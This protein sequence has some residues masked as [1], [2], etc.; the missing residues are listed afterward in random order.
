VNHQKQILHDKIRGAFERELC[1]EIFRS[2]EVQKRVEELSRSLMDGK[3]EALTL[4]AP[5]GPKQD[6]LYCKFNEILQ[7]IEAVT[8][9][10]RCS[11]EIFSSV[12]KSC[13]TRASNVTGRHCPTCRPRQ[14]SS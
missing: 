14:E 5:R 6:N 9:P 8:I 12:M 3:T 1:L 7:D 11:S 2:V 10:L 13:C 4:H